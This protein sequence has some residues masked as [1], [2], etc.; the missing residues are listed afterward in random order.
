M[1]GVRERGRVLL[2]L[3]WSRSLAARSWLRVG[4]P[5]ALDQAIVGNDVVVLQ[6]GTGAQPGPSVIDAPG[7]VALFGGFDGPDRVILRGGNQGDAVSDASFPRA[8]VLGV[9]RLS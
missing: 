3:P 7:H 9:R 6:R 8:R 1:L 2:E 5:I 4:T